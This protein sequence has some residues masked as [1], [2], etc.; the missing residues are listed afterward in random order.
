MDGKI[1]GRG[2]S[3]KR[4][5]PKGLGKG[6]ELETAKTFERF[7]GRRIPGSGSFGSPMRDPSLLGDV[8]MYP[9]WFKTP[10]KGEAKHGYGGPQ[11]MTIKREWFKKIREE[12]RKDHDKIPFLVLKFKGVTSPDPEERASASV[13]AFNLDTFNDMLVQLE[14]W[15]ELLQMLLEK[16]YKERET[17]GV[18]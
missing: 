2:K 11:H 10:M 16:Y 13:I 4:K 7:G 14:E 6:F 8:E 12:A 9:P 5:G 18:E 17:L 15:W 3:E 1:G